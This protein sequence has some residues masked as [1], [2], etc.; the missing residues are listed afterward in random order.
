MI[1]SIIILI[2]EKSVYLF[3]LRMC[4]HD[5]ISTS[6]QW[7]DPESLEKEKELL[8]RVTTPRSFS[9]RRWGQ[10]RRLLGGARGSEQKKKVGDEK[11]SWGRREA[12][13]A[14]RRRG[15][16]EGPKWQ[17][18]VWMLY[19]WWRSRGWRDGGMLRCQKRDE[20]K[21]KVSRREKKHRR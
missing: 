10:R 4:R 7:T 5:W 3:V 21:T 16:S 17:S 18:C 20:R 11:M 19:V 2:L 14:G 13:R 12:K 6:Y 15:V 9:I 1:S 8:K